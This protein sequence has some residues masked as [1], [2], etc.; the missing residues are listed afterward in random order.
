[1]YKLIQNSSSVFRTSDGACIPAATANTDYEQ[2]LQWLADGNTPLPYVEPPIGTPT[3]VTMVQARLALL[4]IG[5]L[6]DVEAGISS[7][8]KASQIEW[9]FRPTVERPSE[10]VQSLAVTLNL[11]SAALDELFTAASKL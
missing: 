9:E 6:D 8:S 2:Y 7:M 11:D 4:A 5:L 3:A 1:M 10:L